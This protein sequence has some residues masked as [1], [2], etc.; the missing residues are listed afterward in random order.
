MQVNRLSQLLFPPA[1]PTVTGGLLDAANTEAQGTASGSATSTAASRTLRAA[2][3][4]R[5]SEPVP[6]PASEAS[7]KLDLDHSQRA[8][9]PV[10]YGP[11]GLFAG[12]SRV[13]V[14]NTPAER[15]V[16]TAVDIMRTYEQDHAQ[17]ATRGPLDRIMQAVSRFSAQ[18]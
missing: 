2:A 4:A 8:Q 12:K 5:E 16:A 9:A 15:F 7:V 6:P 3:T 18:A 17:T 13:E 11:D 14:A 10:T 1:T